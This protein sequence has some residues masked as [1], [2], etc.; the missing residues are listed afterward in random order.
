VSLRARRLLV[1]GLVAASV[2][3]CSILR[4]FSNKPKV[5]FK[6]LDIVGVDFQAAR[7][8]ADLQVENRFK[9]PVKLARIDWAVKIDDNS[10]VSGTNPEG[11][12]VPAEG[13]AL[14]QVP[15]ALKFEDVY[16][17]QQK[18]KDV[19]EAPF[20]LEGTM[21]IDT[22]VGPVSVPFSHEGR[23]PVL[24]IPQVDLAKVDVRGVNMTGADVRLKFNVKNPNGIPL[25]MESLQYALTLAGSK[26][27]DG[28]IPAA[29]A[30][31]A[32]GEGK[33]DADVKVSFAQAAAAAQ[34]IASKSSVSYTLDG[35]LAAK[36]PW[37]TVASP[38]TKTGTN[39]VSQRPPTR[40][41]APSTS[42]PMPP[43]SPIS[44]RRFSRTRKRSASTRR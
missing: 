44:R 17:I 34:A 12:E 10:V 11:L 31:P 37:G 41:I 38:Y 19:D 33:F 27:L 29:L 14:V 42:S 2:G 43:R 24:K 20:R 26:I 6:K 9:V 5:T 35:N 1:L 30:V 25:D 32:K 36:T 28:A 13:T 22:P 8:R 21:A 4:S 23:T 15:F 16:R 3:G 7:L 40:P 39:K 18:Y